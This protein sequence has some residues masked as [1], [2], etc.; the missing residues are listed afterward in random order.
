MDKLIECITDM[1]KH[2]LEL[3]RSINKPKVGWISISTPEEIFYAAGIIPFRMTGEAQRN[4]SEAG[5][6]YS[7]NVCS[8]VIGCLAEG[9]EGIYDFAEGIV[10][11][12]ACDARKRLYDIWNHF[13]DTKHTYLITL[14]KNKEDLSKQYFKMQIL[15]LVEKIKN[16]FN[17]EITTKSLRD[18]IILSN[19]TRKLLQELYEYRKYNVEYITGMDALNIVKASTSGLKEEFNT[20]LELL[21]LKMNERKIQEF[22]DKKHRVLICGSYFDYSNIFESIE[23][24]GARVVCEDISNGYKYFEGKID[25]T[26]DPIEAIANYYFDRSSCARMLDSEERF[27]RLYNLIIEYNVQSVVYFTLKFCDNNLMDYPYMKEKLLEKG[28]S[29]LFI[30]GEHGMNNIQNIRT[31]IHTFLYTKI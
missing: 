7:N 27:E 26:I 31:R 18:A 15:K 29:I 8:Y 13:L 19:R 10:I 28:I 11:T 5:A 6:L 14:S 21:L 3:L 17:C 22:E 25:E 23:E 20:K 4:V 16:D 1:N 9:K 30:E 12:D 2:R 24:C